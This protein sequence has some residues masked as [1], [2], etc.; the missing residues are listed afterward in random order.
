MTLGHWATGRWR[1]DLAAPAISGYRA[2]QPGRRWGD[3][4]LTTKRWW[5]R[6]TDPE[7]VPRR[8]VEVSAGRAAPPPA[9]P[10]DEAL[11]RARCRENPKLAD[12]A[13][14]LIYR[15]FLPVV[16][17]YILARVADEAVAEDLTSETFYAMVKHIGDTRACDEASFAGWILAVARN[18][19]AAYYRGERARPTIQL[20]EPVAEL[21]I[22]PSGDGDP[23]RVATA[24]ESLVE[25][26]Q[27]LDRLTDEQR[28][29]LLYR[30]VYGFSAEELGR[31]FNKKPGAI[32]ALQFRALES[33]ARI[34]RL[35]APAGSPEESDWKGVIRR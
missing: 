27:A 13:L 7:A 26:K 24:R 18:Q 3:L 30:A 22:E 6:R 17:R 21:L 28:H 29:V 2:Q 10:F 8:E 1:D 9:L 35:N 4:L 12:E 33:L 23:L 14:S 34:L 5:G 15:R 25:L 11:R 16:Y 19:V 20:D 32:R 31:E